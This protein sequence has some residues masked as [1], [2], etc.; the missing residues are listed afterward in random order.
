MCISQDGRYVFSVVSF[1]V[2]TVLSGILP[3]V[4]RLC[5]IQ[6]NCKIVNYVITINVVTY[7]GVITD[8]E[9]MF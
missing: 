4:S 2:V 3:R 7:R 9:L 6:L 1:T 5:G 8:P